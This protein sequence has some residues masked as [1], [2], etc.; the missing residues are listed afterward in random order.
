MRTSGTG[1]GRTGTARLDAGV[2]AD[3]AG[4]VFRAARAVARRRGARPALHPHGVV[5]AGRLDV[6][7]QEIR[8]GVPWFDR[9]ASYP[10]TARWSRAAGLPRPL[11]DG[12]G[13]ALRVE[14]ADGPGRS[15]ELLLTSGGRGRLTRHVPIPRV[16]ATAGPYTTL[17]SYVVGAGK[18]VVA[19]FPVPNSPR[20]A[21][22][23]AAVGAAAASRPVVFDLRVGTPA[24]WRPLA[25]LTLFREEH[26]PARHGFDPYRNCLPGF[27][28][29]DR[30]RALRLAAYAGSRA[31]RGG[32]EGATAGRARSARGDGEP[33]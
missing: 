12:L 28:P 10:V 29:V 15:L 9:P 11:P 21:A 13:L 24:G 32:S 8:W 3:E 25:R 1:I 27:H 33:W 6:P 23:P 7:D 30:L 18:G 17:L 5:L 31:G 2:G 26:A 22:D 16:S 14:D 4:V 20:I 19:A